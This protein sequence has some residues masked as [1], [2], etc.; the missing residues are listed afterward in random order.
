MTSW[1]VHLPPGTSGEAAVERL[2]LV[3]DGFTP[4]AFLFGP[5]WAF[6]RRLWLGML[7]FAVLW[8]LAFAL[9]RLA[10]FDDIAQRLVWLATALLIG[11]EA[12]SIERW[13]LKR[14]GWRESD[15][16]VARRKAEAE[17]KAF[18]RSVTTE[19]GGTGEA[20]LP[21]PAAG[22]P[23]PHFATAPAGSFL[24]Q[25]PLLGEPVLGVFPE[26]VVRR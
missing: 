15:V 9:P 26:S 16:V 17:Q 5:I 21:A 2:R 13:T 25:S 19:M 6:I 4:M 10:G 20:R 12:G 7:L 11:L 14:R 24:S 18:E 22:L 8:G 1:T 3:R 23:P